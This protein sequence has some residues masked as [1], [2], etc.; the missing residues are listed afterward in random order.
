MVYLFMHHLFYTLLNFCSI[1]YIGI[2]LIWILPFLKKKKKLYINIQQKGM[3][4]LRFVTF[5]VG[6]S[7]DPKL[8][9]SNFPVIIGTLGLLIFGKT[10]L[11]AL[12][13]KIFGISL[14]SAIRVGLLLAPGGE[15]AFVAFGEAVNQVFV[16]ENYFSWQECLV[17]INKYLPYIFIFMWKNFILCVRF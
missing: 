11:V 4:D 1:T 6:M 10:L 12:I 3:A 8:L 15:F 14:I 7:I 2:T 17:Y 13:G 5:Q 16:L 9:L